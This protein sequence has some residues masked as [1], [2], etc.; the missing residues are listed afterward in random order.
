MRWVPSHEARGSTR[1]SEEDKRGNQGAD[2]LAKSEARRI[3]PTPNQQESYDNKLALLRAVQRTQS[4]ILDAAQRGGSATPGG[5]HDRRRLALV[6]DLHTRERVRGGPIR[7]LH[8]GEMRTWGPHLVV[9]SAAGGYRCIHCS[10][11]ATSHQARRAM[12]R[13]SC[14]ERP[15]LK[16]YTMGGVAWERWNEAIVVRRDR[17]GGDGGHNYVLYAH[18]GQDGRYVCLDC[19][20]HCIKWKELVARQCPGVPQRPKYARALQQVQAGQELGRSAIRR[21]AR[22]QSGYT[23][24]AAGRRAEGYDAGA[25]TNAPRRKGPAHPD[26]RGGAPA[27]PPGGAPRSE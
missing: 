4:A 7:D 10:R 27:W 3:G 12:V 5:E 8:G 6:G 19:G 2:L 18:S 11:H 15:G 14:R 21:D 16:P 17:Q 22:F 25:L 26:F 13:L 1:I 20:R 9:A 23:A 24:A